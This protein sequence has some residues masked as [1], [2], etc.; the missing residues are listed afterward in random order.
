[1]PKS[2][3]DNASPL[4]LYDGHCAL[5]NGAVSWIL[6]WDRR[7]RFT[8]AP[9]Q[10]P[11]AAEIISEHPELSK[12]DSLILVEGNRIRTHSSAALRVAMIVGGLW[13]AL[14]ILYI[15]PK[16]IR[17]WGYNGIARIRYR[18]FGRYD[19]CPMPPVEWRHRFKA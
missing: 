6:K 2:S 1:M 3:S 7:Q 4:L 17:D 18:T 12:I 8:F 9:L 11:T 16:F 14:G 5:C 15:L 13:K 10:G 19:A